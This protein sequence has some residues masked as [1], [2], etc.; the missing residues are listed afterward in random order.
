VSTNEGFENLLKN[1]HGGGGSVCRVPANG[2]VGTVTG[3]WAINVAGTPEVLAEA[4]EAAEAPSSD[5]QNEGP[6]YFLCLIT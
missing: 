6:S 5:L 4:A 3:M 1:D 2:T